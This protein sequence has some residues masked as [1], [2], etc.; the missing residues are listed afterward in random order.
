MT[1]PERQL[2]IVQLACIL[3]LVIC[4]LVFYFVFVGSR[5]PTPTVTITQGVVVLLALWSAV[6]GFTVQR[7]FLQPRTQRT[8]TKST[9]LSRWKAGNIIRLYSAMSVGLWALVLYE[10]GGALWIAGA[11][12]AMSLILLLTWRPGTNPG[13][14]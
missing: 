13:P 10:V 4:I 11:L 12:F 5:E 3:F 8:S 9:P 7:K 6:S 1:K 2:R 14:E